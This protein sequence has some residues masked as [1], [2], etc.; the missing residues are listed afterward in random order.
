[1]NKSWWESSVCWLCDYSTFVMVALLV[2]AIGAYRWLRVTPLPSPAT[3]PTSEFVNTPTNI[4]VTS[5][6]KPP[7]LTPTLIL[8]S[9]PAFTA[10]PAIEKPEFVLV[11]VP[12]NWEFG[13]S[14]F[15]QAAEAHAEIF[16]RESGIEN[17][18]SVRF[19]AMKTGLEGVSLGSDTLVYDIVEFAAM[20]EQPADRYIGLTN[21]DLNPDGESDVVGWTSGGLAVAAEY[22]DEFVVAHELGHTF[23]LCDEY[24]FL[25]WERQNENYSSGCPN[26]YPDADICPHKET[27]NLCEGNPATDGSNSIM[28]PAG[29][30]GDYSFN[31]ACYSHLQGVFKTESKQQ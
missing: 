2:L 23:G 6:R 20:Q 9:T 5:T 19:V 28:G 4:S 10:T 18:F 21:G 22:Q 3:T 24:S 15:E 1:M 16:I 25:D 14:E 30:P 29:M 17:Y 13:L 27:E 31:Q 26:P 12:V 7:T 11:F 8:T